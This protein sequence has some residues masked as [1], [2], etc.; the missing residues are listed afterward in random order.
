MKKKNTSVQKKTNRRPAYKT[1]GTK[2]AAKQTAS[3]APKTKGNKKGKKDDREHQVNISIWVM[4]G[5]LAA[6]GILLIIPYIKDGASPQTGDPLPQGPYCYGID[7]SRY[8]HKIKW[9]SLMVLTDRSG[10][11]I[12]SKTSAKDIR[13]VSFVFIKAT[14]GSSMKDKRFHRHWQDAGKSGAR[15]GAYHF[16]RSS[17]DPVHQAENFIRTVGEISPEDLPPVL[18]IETIHS[19]CTAEMLNDNALTWLRIVGEHY[20]RKPVVYSSAS[21]ISDILCDEITTEYPIWVAHYTGK[22]PRCKNWH[23]WQFTDKAVVYG[24]DGY[25]DMNVCTRAVLKSL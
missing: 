3:T 14:E 7:V 10:R 16:F 1:D 23:I 22:S 4:A 20:G 24:I 12:Y 19:G 25:V 11:T 21:F 8:Q 15:R 17:K 9:D 5:I 13:P 18:D 2:K 6:I